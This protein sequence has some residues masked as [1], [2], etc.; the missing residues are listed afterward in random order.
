MISA[1]NLA[2]LEETCTDLVILDEGEVAY[3]GSMSSFLSGGS[4]VRWT[5]D[6]PLDNALCD[7]IRGIDGVA[8]LELKN[9]T[10]VHLTFTTT[11][12]ASRKTAV[13]TALHAL[14]SQNVVPR[15][16]A[17]GARL[18]ERFLEEVGRSSGEGS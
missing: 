9:A 14:L 12:E 6:T 16:M 2:E 1:H 5:V 17:E 15:T 11:D 3:S 8:S 10:T 4:L 13:K 18:E 7:V